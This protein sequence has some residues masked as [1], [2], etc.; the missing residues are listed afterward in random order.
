MSLLESQARNAENLLKF[1]VNAT[2]YLSSL[3]Q[4]KV[5]LQIT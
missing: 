2:T 1:V 4:D 5:I 3:C